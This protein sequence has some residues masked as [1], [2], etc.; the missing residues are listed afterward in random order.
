[1]LLSNVYSLQPLARCHV[2]RTYHVSFQISNASLNVTY[3]QLFVIARNPHAMLV[4]ITKHIYI[5]TCV[6]MYIYI[7][8]YI[9]DSRM[10]KARACKLVEAEEP[11][12]ILLSHVGT[13]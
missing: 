10:S 12:S 11:V 4:N 1:M 5:Y 7:Y 9:C 3:R 8:I 6:N 2:S 13:M